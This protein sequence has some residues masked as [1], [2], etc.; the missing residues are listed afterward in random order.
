MDVA[1]SEM[2]IEDYEQVYALW[3]S[4][5]GIGL[6]AYC[7]SK[8]GIALYLERN[9]GLSFIARDKKNMVGT[10][11][12]GHDGRRGY[13]HHLA[14]TETYR[15]KGI[16]KALTQRALSELGKLGIKKC[17]LFVF[18]KNIE[19]QKFWQKIGWEERMDLILMSKDID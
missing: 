7:D 16:G 14:I 11:L 4:V 13:L 15:N 2:K 9:P 17:H 19:G 10:V 8:S 3:Q 1:I 12:C 6:H 18:S 5:E